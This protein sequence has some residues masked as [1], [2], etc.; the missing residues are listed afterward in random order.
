MAF[1]ILDF[2]EFRIKKKGK[3]KNNKTHLKRPI[4][5]FLCEKLQYHVLFIFFKH[6]VFYTYSSSY[7]VFQENRP[8]VCF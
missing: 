5:G 4:W 3:R 1:S 7:A 2:S 8:S 6:Y